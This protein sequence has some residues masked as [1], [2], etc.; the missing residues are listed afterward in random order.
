MDQ[1]KGSLPLSAFYVLTLGTLLLLVIWGSRAV[2]VISE[3]LPVR[4]RLCVVIDP[5]HGGI[6]GGATSCTGVPES[7]LNLEIAT[8]LKDLMN[9]L[10]CE[11]KMVRTGDYSIHTEG[12]TI[13]QQKVSDLKERVKIANS[14]PDGIYVSIHQNYFA[15]S[16]YYGPQIFYAATEGS[17]ELAKALNTNL[18]PES[19]RRAKEAQGIYLM[20]QV[21]CTAILV[22]CGFLSNPKEEA[23]LRSRS[24]QQKLCAVLTAGI[25][26]RYNEKEHVRRAPQ[27]YSMM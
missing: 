7:S 2:K 17:C 8:V 23:L 4:D 25:L 27:F 26:E 1:T 12:S 9:F 6:D 5:G 10:G 19:N 11:T 18:A 21:K 16:K 3:N 15:D 13:A 20:E 14:N 24:Y 22:E